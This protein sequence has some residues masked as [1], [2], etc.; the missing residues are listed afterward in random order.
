MYHFLTQLSA[1]VEPER[2]RVRQLLYVDICG[3]II[4]MCPLI[5]GRFA[6]GKERQILALAGGQVRSDL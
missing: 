5:G 6:G 1:A 3:Y 4:I 2:T